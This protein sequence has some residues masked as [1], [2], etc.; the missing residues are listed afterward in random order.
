MESITEPIDLTD[1]RNELSLSRDDGR[2][3][4]FLMSAITVC[5]DRLE[6]IL[7]YYLAERSV[8]FVDDLTM[9]NPSVYTHALKGPVLGIEDVRLRLMDRT[10]VDVPPDA[11]DISAGVLWVD[12]AR[13]TEPEEPTEDVRTRRCA[14]P[15]PMAIEVAYRAGA[16]VPP[17]VKA[18]LLRMVR[19]YYED[20]TAD[21]L[22]DEVVRLV[23]SERRW[24]VR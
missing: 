22:T 16:Y 6:G 9:H 13:A 1:V 4:D 12:L 18:A 24:S 19:I 14:C 5:R 17:V 11:Y 23:S 2:E 8:T 10:W 3:D 20:R 7:P 15:R 21:P